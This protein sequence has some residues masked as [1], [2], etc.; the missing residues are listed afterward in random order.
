M[1]QLNDKVFFSARSAHFVIFFTLILLFIAL[2]AIFFVPL[3]K[4]VEFTGGAIFDVIFLMIP[5][6]NRLQNLLNTRL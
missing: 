6:L 4:S 5:I 1:F 3:N 2:F